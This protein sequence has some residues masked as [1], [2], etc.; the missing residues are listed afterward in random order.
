MN[1]SSMRLALQPSSTEDRLHIALPLIGVGLSF[2]HL[3]GALRVPGEGER[4]KGLRWHAQEATGN[5]LGAG[6]GAET[7]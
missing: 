2:V 7:R 4:F 1:S 5:P 3:D 6:R